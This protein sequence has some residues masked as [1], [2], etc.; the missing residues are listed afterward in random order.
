VTAVRAGTE[1][2]LRFERLMLAL[3]ALAAAGGAER[4]ILSRRTF[5]PSRR[6]S[7]YRGIR[8]AHVRRREA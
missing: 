6:Q 5:M 3:G 4:T 2:S 1:M 8:D 7:T